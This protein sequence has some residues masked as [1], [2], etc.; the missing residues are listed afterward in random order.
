MKLLIQIKLGYKRQKRRY[1]AGKIGDVECKRKL[2]D[3]LVALLGPMR[4]RRLQY[5]KD[6]HYVKSVI[7]GGNS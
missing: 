6:L 1:R 7:Q 2:I 4:E 5:E 3:V